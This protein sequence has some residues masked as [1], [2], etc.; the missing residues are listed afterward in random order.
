[1]QV[2]KL[3]IDAGDWVVEAETGQLG[4]KRGGVSLPGHITQAEPGD[5]SGSRGVGGTFSTL[6]PL[7]EVAWNPLSRRSFLPSLLL[8]VPQ[9]ILGSK[10]ARN[11]E[12][13]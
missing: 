3:L 5:P 9:G 4:Q 7:L 13:L 8:P 12:M 10:L 1:M 11:C 2:I 6:R